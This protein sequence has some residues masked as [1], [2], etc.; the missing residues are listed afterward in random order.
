MSFLVRRFLA[1]MRGVGTL[2]VVLAVCGF[3]TAFVTSMAFGG[4]RDLVSEL[5]GDL[6]PRTELSYLRMIDPELSYVRSVDS[7]EELTA[8]TLDAPGPGVMIDAMSAD[9]RMYI[10]TYLPAFTNPEVFG[11]S[12]ESGVGV[13]GAAPSWLPIDGSRGD[14]VLLWGQMPP[15]VASV[16][17]TAFGELPVVQMSPASVGLGGPGESPVQVG[18]SSQA[19]VLF[20]PELARSNGLD[21]PLPDLVQ[22]FTCECGADEL[23]PLAA[24]MTEAEHDAGTRRA[25]YAIDERNA[26]GPLGLATQAHNSL[27]RIA[28]GGALVGYIL[29]GSGAALAFSRRRRRDYVV[30]FRAGAPPLGLQV[31]QQLMLGFV[32]TVPIALGVGSEQALLEGG[33]VSPVLVSV[34]L[35]V[36]IIVGSAPWLQMSRALSTRQ[37]R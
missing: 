13:I 37:W 18:A 16:T 11:G 25:Y 7:L 21:I 4:S 26:L 10:V 23:A 36:Q 15:G 22:G 35:A 27:A 8:S 6:G 5:T 24:A 17:N 31:R 34:V 1:D 2:S 20:R 9:D 32:L 3:V 28:V 12:V 29:L 30:E 14:A 33:V 19:V